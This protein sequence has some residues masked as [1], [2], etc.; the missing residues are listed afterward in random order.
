MVIEI[1]LNDLIRLCRFASLGKVI[2]G[3][4][5]N[6]NGPLQNLGMDIEMMNNS[7]AGNGTS[8]DTL[9]KD[10]DIRLKRI[11]E[12][13][14]RLRHLTKIASLRV[15]LENDYQECINLNDFLQHELS[16]LEANLYFKHNVH[17]ELQLEDGLPQ[18]NILPRG[19]PLSLSWFIH[20]FI[21]EMERQ[22][23]GDMI[24]K[25][26]SG[27]S[28][29]EIILTTKGGDLSEKFIKLLD[30]ENSS[31][32]L[33]RIENVEVEMIL[34]LEGLK[35]CGVS[36]RG[37]FEPSNSIVILTIPLVTSQE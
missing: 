4:L 32:E 37:Q 10:I 23:I 22:G 16:F 14:E 28:G 11:E 30:M 35:S 25:A 36:M 31:F 15:S 34:A 17:T 3:L 7:L 33:L 5:H 12:E 29:L 18:L 2:D 19:V 8:Y 24:L 1:S 9:A 27:H 20:S 6:I 21:E 13:F 26:G